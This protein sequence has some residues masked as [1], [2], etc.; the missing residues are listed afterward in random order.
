M[1][2]VAETGTPDTAVGGSDFHMNFPTSGSSMLT[3]AELI[4][5]YERRGQK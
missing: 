5:V 2:G 4:D 3:G 1:G